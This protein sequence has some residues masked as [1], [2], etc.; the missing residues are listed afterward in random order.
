MALASMI[1]NG[2]QVDV[3]TALAA[4][5]MTAIPFTLQ[6]DQPVW[7]VLEAENT[8]A[9]SPPRKA[10]AHVDLTVRSLLPLWVLP[11]SVGGKMA[12]P[13]EMEDLVAGSSVST[14]TLKQLASA[15]GGITSSPRFFRN[16]P[17]WSGAFWGYIVAAVAMDQWTW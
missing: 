5:S 1:Q 6:P 17:Q 9:K 3:A 13:G 8:A 12:L 4:K 11:E 16:F 10:F 2:R 7:Q 15:L 14:V